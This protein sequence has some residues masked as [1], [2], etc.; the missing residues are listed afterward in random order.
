M[1]VNGYFYPQNQ[2]TRLE[3]TL[4]NNDGHLLT[5]NATDKPPITAG[6]KEVEVSARLG[7][8]PRLIT[9]EDGSSFETTEN[10]KVDQLFSNHDDLKGTQWIHILESHLVFVIAVVVFVSA[11]TLG[12]V[13]YGVPAIAHATAKALPIEVNQVLAKGSL[14]VLDK[15]YFSE[16][17][18]PNVRQQ[19][20]ISQFTRYTEPYADLNISIVFRNGN[21]MGANA[22]A[23]PDGHIVFTDEIVELAENDEELLS[24]FFHEVGHLE[25][26]HLLRRIIQDSMLAMLVVLV[27]GDVSYASSVVLAL[28]ALLVELAYSRNFEVEADE[29][30]LALMHKHNI[31]TAFFAHIMR[32]ITDSYREENES[33]DE[34]YSFTPYLSTHPMTEER[35]LP[36]LK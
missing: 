15:T 11:F 16:S 3:A 36:F 14:E 7:Q 9:F 13:Q 18:L 4:T 32:R 12:F 21:S 31:D 26:R 23:L 1:I 8:T 10:D 24:I 2:S 27:T 20:L 28:P 25:H 29:F 34:H 22:F 19:Q 5:L 35:I 17:A 30:A 6:L 33:T